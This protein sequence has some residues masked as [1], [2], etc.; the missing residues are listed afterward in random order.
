VKKGEA[1]DASV[2][3]MK[4]IKTVSSKRAEKKMSMRL[5][6]EKKNRKIESE[7]FGPLNLI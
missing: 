4:E 2:S 7:I 6:N 3:K 1:D 5:K